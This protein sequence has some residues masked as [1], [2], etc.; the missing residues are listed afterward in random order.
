MSFN[1]ATRRREIQLRVAEARQRDVGRGKV[2]IDP[3]VMR[4]LGVNPGDIVEI[5]GKRKTAAIVWPAYPE[6]QDETI[7]RMDGLIRK[8]AG[9]SIG[10]KVTIRKASARPASLV[11]LAPS[12][13]SITVD[14]AFVNFV[15]KRLYDYPLT[16]GDTVL[17]PV[18]GQ[19]IPF[20]VVLTRPAGIV[21]VTEDTNLIILEKPAEEIRVPRVTYEDIGG[22]QEAIQKIREMVELPL[23]HPELFK[24]LGIDP[25]KGCL[26]Y[27]SPSPRDRG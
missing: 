27:T 25:P 12:S 23:K 17:I 13:F 3:H 24:R 4:K 14:S 8:N 18:L 26:L 1:S 20:T 22:L 11:K 21:L 16:Q 15:K 9:V 6:D 5:E 7:I 19:A 2:R 10:E